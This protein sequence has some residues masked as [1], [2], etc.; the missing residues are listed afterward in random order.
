M[1]ELNKIY[2]MDVIEG[3][4]EIPDKSIDLVI[5]DPFYVPK[6]QFEW[7]T[8]DKFYWDWNKQWLKEI[9]RIVKDDFHF[10]MSFSSDDMARFDLLLQELGFIIK[11]RIVWNY[12]NSAKATAKD[13][14]WAKT[15]EFI[16]HCSS[17]KK[18][19]FPEKWD[20]RRFDVKTFAIPQSNFKDGKFHQY[21][22][23]LGLWRELIEFASNKGDLVLDPF[24]GSGTTALVCQELER[25]FIGFDIKKE[26]VDIANR[27]IQPLL[28]QTKLNS[29][30][31]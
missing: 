26:Y 11:S 29:E 21:Q 17:G 4:K 24:M 15:Y 20:D 13:T 12:R 14:K 30:S 8:F 3:L 22:K 16:F 7:E 23:P 27:R 19:N 10:L 18:L 25:N 1:L 5:T 28:E 2:N 6:A 9:K 31:S